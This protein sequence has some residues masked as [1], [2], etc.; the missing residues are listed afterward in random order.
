MKV[1]HIEKAIEDAHLFINAAT[2]ALHEQYYA[3]PITFM[4]KT[5]SPY[6]FDIDNGNLH[7]GHL[8]ANIKRKSMDLTRSLS[9][10][11]QGK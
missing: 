11:R 8:S 9:K 1:S 5:E 10:M 3:E 7:V 2:E 6:K 4:G